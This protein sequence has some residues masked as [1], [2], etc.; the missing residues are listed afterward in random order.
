MVYTISE[1]ENIRIL[2][3]GNSQFSYY[4]EWVKEDRTATR[5]WT[6]ASNKGLTLTSILGLDLHDLGGFKQQILVASQFKTPEV[7][8]Q[9]VSRVGCF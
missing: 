7:R 8:N 5:A 3:S 2:Y 9:G 4:G 1:N 6:L